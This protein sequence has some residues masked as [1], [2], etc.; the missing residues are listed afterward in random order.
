M[1]ACPQFLLWSPATAGCFAGRPGVFARIPGGSGVD[2]FSEVLNG[3]KLKG[4]LYFRAEFSA[5]WGI[6]APPSGAL[7]PYL[8]PGAEHL[9]IYH[10][11]TDGTAQAGIEGGRQVRLEPGDIVILP[12][13]HPHQ[14]GSG[15]AAS[16]IDDAAVL[17]RIQTR[18]LE[19][20]RAG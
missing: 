10:F 19:P 17:E 11:V 16:R 14:M 13:G 12:H 1:P 20:M 4:A 5:P 2:A 7:A 6:A 8:Y 3:V 9:I 18:Q 15:G